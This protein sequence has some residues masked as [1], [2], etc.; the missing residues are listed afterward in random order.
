MLTKNILSFIINLKYN[1]NL[2]F[3]LVGET[4]GN[5][6]MTEGNKNNFAFL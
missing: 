5:K 2:I 4:N 1:N 6:L 3:S